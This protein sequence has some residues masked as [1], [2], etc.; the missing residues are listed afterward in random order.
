MINTK[1]ADTR[2][3]LLLQ[4]VQ[5]QSQAYLRGRYSWISSRGV[6]QALQRRQ[7][8]ESRFEGF[9]GRMFEYLGW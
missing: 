9:I 8:K 3:D 4:A 5:S 1:N 6:V 7:A 2:N